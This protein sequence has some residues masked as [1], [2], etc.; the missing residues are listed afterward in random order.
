[1][2]E[3]IGVP[4]EIHRPVVNQT[5]HKVVSS[6][7]RQVVRTGKSYIQSGQSLGSDRG[8]KKIYVKSKRSIVI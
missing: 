3:E 5:S 7:P 1:M 8:K 6:T 4:G 2:V